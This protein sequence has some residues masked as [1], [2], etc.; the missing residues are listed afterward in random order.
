MRERI[1][2]FCVPNITPP[3]IIENVPAQVC[4]RCG[5]EVFSDSTLDVF[6]TIRD[7]RAPHRIASVRVFDFD[8]VR[9]VD[10][11]SVALVADGNG[12]PREIAV[13]VDEGTVVGLPVP[14]SVSIEDLYAPAQAGTHG[15][16]VINV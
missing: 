5:G 15:W 4:T 11:A 9:Q 10:G 2:R 8:A 13:V 6:E 1:V 3:V 14:I 7:G 16:P 12:S